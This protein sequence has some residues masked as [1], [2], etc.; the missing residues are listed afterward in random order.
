[1][2]MNLVRLE[3]RLK[4]LSED[5]LRE[6]FPKGI[7]P[8]FLIM[9]ELNRRK[10]VKDEYQRSQAEQGTTVAEDLLTVT[11][12]P[13][14]VGM[15]RMGV[16]AQPQ[17][18]M[19]MQP[20]NLP[21][22]QSMAAMPSVPMMPQE[23]P[24]LPDPEP[25][26]MQPGGL[27]ALSERPLFGEGFREFDRTLTARVPFLQDIKSGI[28][29][30]KENVPD[31][32]G[33]LRKG[34]GQGAI[35]IGDLGIGL[36]NYFTGANLPSLRS[37]QSVEPTSLQQDRGN[38]K[39]SPFALQQA[40]LVQ[41][42]AA[43]AQQ[44]AALAQ[45]DQDRPGIA[46]AMTLS[47][48]TSNKTSPPVGSTVP[49]QTSV[50]QPAA[51]QSAVD[52][53]AQMIDT[54][55]SI[56]SDPN[57]MSSTLE[58]LGMSKINFEL[59]DTNPA[60]N[61]AEINTQAYLT[62]QVASTQAALKDSKSAFKEFE[63]DLKKMKEGLGDKKDRA[64]GLALL[65]A[66]LR[67]AGSQSPNLSGA[68]GEAAPALQTFTKSLD[69]IDDDRKNII[70]SKLKLVQAQQAEL[71]GKKDDARQALQDARQF[72]KDIFDRQNQIENR[73]A[74]N[75]ELRARFENIDLKRA[76]NE[77]T[78][79]FNSAKLKI[80][81]NDIDNRISILGIKKISLE[82]DPN[83]NKQ[84]IKSVEK[85]LKILNRVKRDS[86]GKTYNAQLNSLTRIL[87]GFDKKIEA[88][89]DPVKKQELIREKDLY[90]G[91]YDQLISGGEIDIPRRIPLIKP[92]SS[93]PTV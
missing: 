76:S 55:T 71:R 56:A 72:N 82:N 68:I 25:M 3:E 24:A 19:E 88:E 23:A 85:Q 93:K 60:I 40:P 91:A 48:A 61:D 27:A 34:I 80:L 51:G 63:D 16:M 92:K 59:L 47:T 65:E 5:Q 4:D 66:G 11:D 46:D 83:A 12:G 17:N 70:N 18:R 42:Q 75:A 64:V 10:E 58:P 54:G 1:M 57:L 62:N 39:L 32:P 28:D 69:Q 29:A 81:E 33:I 90:Q 52:Q 87:G 45:D 50:G 77:E 89:I 20:G 78:K 8:Q 35:G 73:K 21:V 74:K 53:S 15:E 84:Q 86:T 38:R 44:Q 2:V 67:I 6:A 14:A 49:Q 7:I 22:E 13:M 26:R 37:L 43:L 31:V 79:R 30:F 41:Q 9:S 36:A